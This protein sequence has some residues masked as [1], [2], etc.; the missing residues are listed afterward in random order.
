M[1]AFLFYLLSFTWGLP[2]TAAG[3]IC[4]VFVRLCGVRSDRVGYCRRFRVGRGWGG[5]SLGPFVFVGEDEPESTAWHEHGHGIQNCFFGPLMIFLVSIPSA[6][7]YWYRRLNENKRFR[8]AY[9]DIWFEAQATR[10]GKKQRGRI[11]RDK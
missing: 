11:G 3:F 1:R 7:R 5:F 10:L 6:V 8:H 2:I 9:G 4:A